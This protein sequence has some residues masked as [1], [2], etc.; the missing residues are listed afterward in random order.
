M[1]I[2]EKVKCLRC[3][4]SGSVPLNND[5][6][7][8]FKKCP[9]CSGEGKILRDIKDIEREELFLLG[10]KTYWDRISALNERQEEKGRAK[11]GQD[12]EENVTMPTD[13]RIEHIQEELI[14]ALKYLEHFKV[15]ASADGMT[16]NDYQRAALRTASGM[17][18]KEHGMLMNGALG[19]C[20]EAGEVADLV[21]KS[22]FQGHELD[23]EKVREELGD[24]AWYLAVASHAIG[25]TL[26]QVFQAN[27]EK[28]KQR[29]PD[30]FSKE[31]SVNR[32]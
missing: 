12:L 6:N 23:V 16:A 22:V 5:T 25:L 28:L 4:G 1:A 29:Y 3:E 11:Y 32:G 19:L 14:D 2:W 20:G 15:V 30:G 13:Q 21:K 8:R 9:E 24:V 31:R 26:D 10:R 27:I 17:N 7:R 18:Y